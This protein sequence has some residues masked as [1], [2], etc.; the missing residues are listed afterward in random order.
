MSNISLYLLLWIIKFGLRGRMVSE[1][2]GHV[3]E[4]WGHDTRFL[5]LSEFLFILVSGT[6]HK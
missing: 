6:H 3:T 1:I 4:I 5:F 2:W